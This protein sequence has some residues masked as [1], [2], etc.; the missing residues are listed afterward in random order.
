MHTMLQGDDAPWK[1]NLKKKETF[2]TNSTKSK[3]TFVHHR[4]TLETLLFAIDAKYC[5]GN[6]LSGEN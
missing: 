2:L 3:H 6:L 4:V 1:R 5:T